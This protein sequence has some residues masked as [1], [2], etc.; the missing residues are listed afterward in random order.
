MKLLL[1]LALTLTSIA[2][3]APGLTPVA[4]R[5]EYLESPLGLDEPHPR[6]T[7]RIESPE[8]GQ[9]QIAYHILVASDEKALKQD[10]GDLWDSGKVASD[11]TVNIVY[12]GKALWSRQSCF[13]KVRV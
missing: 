7:W 3:G 6:L 5:C 10:R 2:Q 1:A 8:R 9:K 11:E 4:L 13:W 12:A